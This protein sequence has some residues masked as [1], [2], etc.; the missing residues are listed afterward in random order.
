MSYNIDHV[1]CMSLDAR[2]SAKKLRSLHK[3]HEDEMA[4]GNFIWEHF[5]REP[6]AEGYVRLENLCWHGESSGNSVQLFEKLLT[7]VEGTAEL[8]LTWEGGDSHT[9]YRVDNGCVQECE[10][11]MVVGKPVRTIGKR[12]AR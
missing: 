3:K 8:I 11:T 9:A 5:E 1:E 7:H 12:R 4:E 6:D 10:L 2:M